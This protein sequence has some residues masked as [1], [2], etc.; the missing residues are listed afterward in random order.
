MSQGIVLDDINPC[1]RPAYRPRILDHDNKDDR[2][3][4]Y[5]LLSKLPPP[6]RLAWLD[7]ACCRAT[8]GTSQVRPVVQ[9]K[10]RRLAAQARWDSAADARLTLEIFFDLWMLSINYRVD[11]EALLKGLERQVRRL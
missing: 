4:V 9:Q 6:K 7:W 8:L 1:V 2:L 3:E 11:F 5:H 10:T